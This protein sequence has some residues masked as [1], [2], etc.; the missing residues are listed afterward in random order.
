MVSWPGIVKSHTRTDAIV[1]WLDFMPTL[2]ELVG[3]KA[4][5]G[6][7]GRS[8]AGVV[9]GTTSSH[10]DRIYTTHTGDGTWNIYPMRSLRADGWKYILNL[11]PEYAFT[12]HIDL[13]GELTQREMFVTWEQAAQT[14]TTAK[15]IV[16]RYHARPAEE[17]YDLSKD[18]NEEHNVAS[19]PANKSRLE[20]MRREVRE[21]MRQQGDKER[22][23]AKPRLLSDPTAYGPGAGRGDAKR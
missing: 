7:D 23:L 3:G 15:E 2:L 16:N 18:P 8:F 11:H 10:R 5:E 19:N 6:I 17:L 22:T 4:P 12:C 21:T 9:R 13:S 20:A 1:S 14:S